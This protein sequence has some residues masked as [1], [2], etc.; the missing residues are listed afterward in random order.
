MQCADLARMHPTVFSGGGAPGR[1]PR[2]W[3]PSAL[4]GAMEA[5]AQGVYSRD[6]VGDAFSSICISI[7]GSI[8]GDAAAAAA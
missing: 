1:R 3:P 7:W 2:S 5:P 6:R 8:L 4:A